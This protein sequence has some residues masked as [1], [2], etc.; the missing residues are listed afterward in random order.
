[1]KNKSH[2]KRNIVLI[3]AI[4]YTVIVLIGTFIYTFI[5]YRNTAKTQEMVISNEIMN[6]ILTSQKYYELLT[7]SSEENIMNKTIK[8]NVEVEIGEDIN[9]TEKRTYVINSKNTSNGF[10]YLNKDEIYNDISDF[11]KKQESEYE[12]NAKKK[13]EENKTAQIR[14]N[15][16]QDVE[17]TVQ[18][19]ATAKNYTIKFKTFDKSLDE[20]SSR[21][22]K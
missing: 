14:I 18:Q 9:K 5:S 12:E 22:Y 21:K 2:K 15:I 3:I 8:Y 4:S 7:V 6:N 17:K 16:L 11:K 20:V 1:M 19:K 10:V 13:E